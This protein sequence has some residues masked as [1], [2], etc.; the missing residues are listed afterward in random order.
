MVIVVIVTMASGL[1]WTPAVTPPFNPGGTDRTVL[2]IDSS[3]YAVVCQ[4]ADRKMSF[5]KSSDGLHWIWVKYLPMPL[6]E[7][8][9]GCAW[10]GSIILCGGDTVDASGEFHPTQ[11]VWKIET[12]G[13]CRRLPKATWKA[14][15]HSCLVP[16]ESSNKLILLGGRT[17][18][19]D[20]VYVSTDTGKTW[21]STCSVPGGTL[22]QFGT[23]AFGDSVWIF[24]G[25]NRNGN[26]VTNLV[27]LSTDAGDSW[28]SDS[29]PPW[30]PR[31]SFG[32]TQT[33]TSI[34]MFGGRDTTDLFTG[35]LDEV[36]EYRVAD[37]VWKQDTAA[38]TMFCARSW[39]SAAFF[40]NELFVCCGVK[41][42][43]G[44]GICLNDLYDY[45]VNS[46]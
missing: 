31:A 41:S 3:L 27:W 35:Y 30:S 39:P 25:I 10:Q 19:T 13:A 34:W 18:G 37:G 5:Y 29:V 12:S 6:T 7:Y 2:Q 14:R 23:A 32:Y 40:R 11:N 36:W 9:A 42:S 22:E 15:A 17:S 44:S 26:A 21:T 16:L 1:D 24:G 8:F 33:D 4:D 28:K 38:D 20:S 45:A 43:G 46:S